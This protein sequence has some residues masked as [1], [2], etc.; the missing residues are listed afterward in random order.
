MRRMFFIALAALLS[1][2][3]WAEAQPPVSIHITSPL[4]RTGVEGKIRFVAQII[5]SSSV[6]L[7]PVRFLVNGAMVGEDS[8][9]APYAIDW[10]DENPFDQAELKVEVTDQ[11]GK[12]Y[13]DTIVLEPYEIIEAAQVSSVLIE[14]TVQNKAGRFVGG[15]A[16]GDFSVA[17][18]DVPQDLDLVR[19]TDVP[20]TFALLVDSS[21][22]MSRRMD[23][24]RL[25]ARR[26]SERMRPVDRVL[27]VPFSLEPQAIT[28]PTNDKNTIT[29]AIDAIAARGGTAIL[30]S[31]GEV[32]GRVRSAE[33]R[34]VI[35]LITDG[36]DENSRHT[37][38]ETLKDVGTSQA[39]VYVVGIPGVAGI[40]LQGERFLRQIAAATGGRAFFPYREESLAEVYEV[41]LEDIANR[42]LITYTPSNQTADG[43]FRRVAVEAR[44]DGLTVHAREGYFAPKPPPIRPSVEFTV[45]D[46]V[47]N[48]V[49]VN[50]QE[51]S[52]FEDGIEQTIESFQEAVSPVSIVLALDQSGSMRRAADAVMA[53]A[54]NFVEALRPE[55]GLAVVLFADHSVF[56]QDLSTN[57]KS[58][59]DAIDGYLAAGGTA[60]YDAL[61]DSLTRLGRVQGRRAVVVV[62]DGRDEDNPGTG[63]GSVNTLDDVLEHQRTT[64]A[65]IFAVGLGPNVDQATLDRLSEQSG[66]QAYFPQNVDVLPAVYGRIVEALRRRFVV[67]YTSTNARRD[68]TWRNVEI[69]TRSSN[70]VVRS[71]GGYFAPE[72]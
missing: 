61:V 70:L 5:A 52:V 39:T 55:D 62:T 25:A 67:S 60:L 47:L 58:S 14:A 22:S 54:R 13:S 59:F 8:D 71:A 16:E 69:K 4:G 50:A 56:V 37:L 41:L 68:G 46:A 23:F 72:R 10:I 66:A 38:E 31:L 33:G 26:L 28:G 63:P 9:G 32:A 43:K 44:G 20:T 18:D 57:R 64:G 65:L 3:S 6:T 34:R 17:E 21:Q 7:G 15:L 24:V 11:A 45:T 30:D 29:Q 40:S 12:V 48:Y 53:T 35:V 1:C 36:Y 19:Q 49:D 42:Y 51:L 2:A 27:V